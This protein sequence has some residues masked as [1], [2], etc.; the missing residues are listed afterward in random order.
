MRR[1]TYLKKKT[2]VNKAH[3]DTGSINMLANK[4][5]RKMRSYKT[6]QYEKVLQICLHA[7]S[8]MALQH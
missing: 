4:K 8:L 7:Q 5:N 2:A 6:K 1:K 3:L